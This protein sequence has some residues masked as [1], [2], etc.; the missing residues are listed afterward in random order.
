M[1]GKVSIVDKGDKLVF[2]IQKPKDLQIR[3]LNELNEEAIRN[4]CDGCTNIWNAMG[5][6]F[7]G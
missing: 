4:I 2:E 7:G 5:H 3:N 1:S 6:F